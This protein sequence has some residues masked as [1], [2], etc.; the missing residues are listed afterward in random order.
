M[1]LALDARDIPGGGLSIVCDGVLDSATSPELDRRITESLQ[2]GKARLVCDLSKVTYISSAG[3][4]VLVSALHGC[5]ERKGK[6]VL[7]YPEPKDD[8]TGL[9]NKFNPLEVFD[10]LGLRQTFTIV[11]TLAEA[12]RQVVAR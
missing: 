3:V 2:K 12:E 9:S 10:L 5:Q 1:S 6:L 8:R 4:G 7:V 11:D